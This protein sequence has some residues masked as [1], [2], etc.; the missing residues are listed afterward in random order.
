MEIKMKV[1]RLFIAVP[2]ILWLSG[3]AVNMVGTPAEQPAASAVLQNQ[4]RS[5]YVARAN[6]LVTRRM[7]VL[8]EQ[9]ERQALARTGH[10]VLFPVGTCTARVAVAANGTVANVRITQCAGPALA[11]L[12]ATAI[13]DSSPL[14]P[15]PYGN[16]ANIVLGIRNVRSTFTER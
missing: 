5:D 16:N 1:N 8:G 13:R 14:P 4:V 11:R 7:Q 12:F 15:T 2:M 10:P 3:C 6:V 9:V